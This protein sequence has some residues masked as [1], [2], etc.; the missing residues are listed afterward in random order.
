[1]AISLGLFDSLFW[2][3]SLYWDTWSNKYK[4]VKML[5]EENALKASID[6]PGYDKETLNI[7]FK[8]NLLRI[9]GNIKGRE[10]LYEWEINT[11]KI[12]MENVKAKVNK[13]ILELLIPYKIPKDDSYKIQIE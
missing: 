4:N 7:S 13:G 11:S 6:V 5:K 9:E 8:D 10:L 1:M 12:D 2:D 3:D